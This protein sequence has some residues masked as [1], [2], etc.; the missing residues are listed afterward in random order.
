MARYKIL[1]SELQSEF[2][3]E[4]QCTQSRLPNDLG[5]GHS[6]IFQVD[7]GLSYINTH[8]VPSK[9]ISILSQR[10]DRNAKLVLTLG[11]D[12]SSCFAGQDGSDVVF[13]KGYSTVTCF[14]SSHGE[15]Q[16]EEGLAI[17]QLRLTLNKSWLDRYIGSENSDLIFANSNIQVLSH[18][19]TAQQSLL[20]AQ[21]LLTTEN[22]APMRQLYM[23]T[24]V[25]NL[26]MKELACLFQRYPAKCLTDNQADMQLANAARYILLTEFKSPPSVEKLAKQIG[27]NSFKLKKIFHQYFETTP[28]GLLL[29]VRMQKAA[30]LLQS[31]HCNVS[32]AAY[33]VGYSHASNFSSAFVKFYGV[34]PKEVARGYQVI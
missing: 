6:N 28:Y 12:G 20:I 30:Q 22:P 21:Q 16:Y 2:K 23:H 25:M 15:R 11:I 31:T 5:V 8:Y 3:A 29:E 19:P 34:S 26:L 4:M 24:Q 1:P 32:V 33:F 14:N 10:N 7:E 13:K 27:T 17:H 9:D 18:K